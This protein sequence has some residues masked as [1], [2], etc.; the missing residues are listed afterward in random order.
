MQQDKP[1][2]GHDEHGLEF[3]MKKS[4]FP[5]VALVALAPAWAHG[6]GNQQTVELSGG[7]AN[8]AA[9]GGTAVMNIS[10]TQGAQVIS[11]NSQQVVVRGA[12][13]NAAT[14]GAHSELNIASR[15]GPGSGSGSQVISVQGPVVNQAAGKGVRSVVNIGGR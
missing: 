5:W 2:I 11:G 12:V 8:L 9:T 4:P 10:S 15:T 13:L 3:E 14:F 6:A 1:R 7:A